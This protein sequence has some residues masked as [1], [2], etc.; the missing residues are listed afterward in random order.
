MHLFFAGG[1]G[2]IRKPLG[3]DGDDTRQQGEKGLDG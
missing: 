1:S 2:H 3:V